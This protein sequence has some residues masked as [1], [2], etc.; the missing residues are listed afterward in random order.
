ME[1]TALKNQIKSQNLQNLYNFTGDEVAVMDIYINQIA[2]V[3]NLVTKRV[4]S[5]ADIYAKL[6][7][8]SFV[9]TNFCYIIRDDKEYITNEKL[10][11]EL[12]TVIGDNIIIFIT[13]SVDKRSKFYKQ[14]KDDFV[15]FE[16][17]PEK[18]LIKYIQKDINLS[19][20]CC[21]YL[22]DVCESDYSRILLEIDKVKQYMKYIG[23]QESDRTLITMLKEGSIFKPAKDAIFDF[24]DAVVTRKIQLAFSLYEECKE[25][26]ES[27]IVLLSVLYNNFKQIL[28][29]QSCDN[30]DIAKSTGLSG[31]QIKNAKERMGKYQIYELVDILRVIQHTEASIKQ[32]IMEE[33]ISINY[34]L[35]NIL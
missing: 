26:G 23:T 16:H 17:L 18:M 5:I 24:V 32:G 1:L 6:K 13:T 28:Q 29:V 11:Q 2:K 22:I 7:N 4:D 3:K 12:P 19:D 20:K 30:S 25:V 15:T 9:N 33:S 31:W 14:F 35:A 34:V 10:W 21:K 8:K 27:N